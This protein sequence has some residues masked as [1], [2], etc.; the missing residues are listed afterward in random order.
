M[1]DCKASINY[2]HSTHTSNHTGLSDPDNESGSD[3]HSF[4]EEDMYSS[5]NRDD[6]ISDCSEDL[7]HTALEAASDQQQSLVGMKQS[8]IKAIMMEVGMGFSIDVSDL[9]MQFFLERHICT[10]AY[11]M[12]DVHAPSSPSSAYHFQTACSTQCLGPEM[13]SFPMLFQHTQTKTGRTRTTE[14][15]VPVI[16]PSPAASS[17]SKKVSR[18]KI[19]AVGQESERAIPTQDQTE[20]TEEH[21]YPDEQEYGGPELTTQGSQP[22]AMEV[23]TLDGDAKT[24]E[25]PPPSAHKILVWK[26]THALF[27]ALAK[28]TETGILLNTKEVL[29]L[30]N[31]DDPQPDGDYIDLQCKLIDFRIH[32][33]LDIYRMDECFLVMLGELSRGSAQHLCQFSW[34]K[35]LIPL[36]L[37]PEVV[38]AELTIK[39][40]EP[41]LDIA[42]IQEWIAGVEQATVEVKEEESDGIEES[43]SI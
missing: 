32:N 10:L 43:L 3:V 19:Q 15:V 41:L 26:A 9:P 21:E 2:L 25:M 11:L 35:I 8:P 16:L 23:R 13:L 40:I 7:A 4:D 20:H 29:T 38:K 12:E 36:Q 42:R 27:V 22:Q 33:V 17:K 14:K 1:T 31:A 18:D 28:C 6:I 37:V 30:L 24:Y 34:D 5:D 39:Y